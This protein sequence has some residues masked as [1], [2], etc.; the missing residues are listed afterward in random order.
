MNLYAKGEHEAALRTEIDTL[1]NN[2]ET[3]IHDLAAKEEQK[4]AAIEY[5]EHWEILNCSSQTIQIISPTK[6][7]LIEIKPGRTG[8][9]PKHLLD[10]PICSKGLV[11]SLSK[12]MK[13]D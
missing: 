4:K 1:Y 3:L 8:E 7:K 2:L 10:E 13:F 5:D 6:K 11:W 12:R 9:I